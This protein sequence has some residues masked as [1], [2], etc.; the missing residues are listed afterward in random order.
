M[1]GSAYTA[2]NRKPILRRL[3]SAHNTILARHQVCVRLL[4]LLRAQRGRVRA[5]RCARR[6]V[7]AGLGRRCVTWETIIRT[8]ATPLGPPSDSAPLFEVLLV[9]STLF[10]RLVMGQP[11]TLVTVARLPIVVVCAASP[12]AADRHKRLSA[13]SARRTRRRRR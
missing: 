9:R 8:S 1:N 3:L 4:L 7:Q 10:S 2:Q 11:A 6:V 12:L 13:E 5:P